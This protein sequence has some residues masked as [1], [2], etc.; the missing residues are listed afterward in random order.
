MKPRAIVCAL[1]CLATACGAGD[2]QRGEPPQLLD[3]VSPAEPEPP[4]SYEERVA[5]LS[6]DLTEREAIEVLLDGYCG[7]CHASR[8]SGTM[9]DGAGMYYVDDAA[10]L[11]RQLKIIPGEP[12]RSPLVLRTVDGSMPP[13]STGF[14]APPPEFIERLSVFIEGLCPD[15]EPCDASGL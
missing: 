15:G 1:L 4:P 6:G 11:I 10:Q 12:L 8:L 5:E 9:V 13:E 14:P 7:E 2:G 3:D